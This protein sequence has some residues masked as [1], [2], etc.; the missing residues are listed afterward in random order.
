M[1]RKAYLATLVLVGFVLGLAVSGRLIIHAQE[2]PGTAARGGG[3]DGIE[4]MR[5]KPKTEDVPAAGRP[6]Q[7]RASASVQDVLLRPYRFDFDRATPLTEVC[8]RLKR[9]LGISVVLDLAALERQEVEPEDTVQLE[10]DGVRLKTGLKLLL[11]QVK[12]TY[13]VVPEDNLLIITDKEGSDDPLDRIW[14]ELRTLH[15]EMHDMQDAVDELTDS[16]L[17]EEEGPRMRKPT[18][19]EEMPEIEVPPGGHDPFPAEPAERSRRPETRPRAIPRTSPSPDDAPATTP[20]PRTTPG[21]V[22]LSSRR[23]TL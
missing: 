17:V 23:R 4:P 11:D 7:L 6:G 8:L 1:N 14:S 3:D 21:R 16:I 22:P 18:I 9:S 15:R 13:R 5:P 20:A 2:R 10:L 12:L 19:I